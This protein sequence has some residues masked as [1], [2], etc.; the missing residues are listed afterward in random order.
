MTVF[1]PTAGY[2]SYNRGGGPTWVPERKYIGA[3]LDVCELRKLLGDS[4]EL[5]F[6][7]KLSMKDGSTRAIN[8]DGQSYKN[9]TI[10]K[11]EL[12]PRN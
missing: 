7:V 1:E 12:A 11:D 4:N 9:F 3:G 10:G 2:N 5:S 6:W 8:L